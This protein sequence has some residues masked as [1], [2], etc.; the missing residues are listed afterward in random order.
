MMPTIILP[1]MEVEDGGGQASNIKQNMKFE[2]GYDVGIIRKPI[3]E[4][5]E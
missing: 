2:K 4:S 5:V 1:G 3:W